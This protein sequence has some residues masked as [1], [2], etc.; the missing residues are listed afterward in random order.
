MK[1]IKMFI[2]TVGAALTIIAGSVMTFADSQYLTPAEALAELTARGA[3]SVINE[4]MRTGKTYGAIAN[5]AGVLN[6]FKT[7]MLEMRKAALAALV[8]A[9]VVTQKQADEIIAEI[10]YNM[11]FCDGG[12]AGC[13][14][15]DTGR[16]MG[17]G[18]G[19]RGAGR[20]IGCGRGMGC[21][22]RNGMC[23]MKP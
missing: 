16:G 14:L 5:E 19:M 21:G 13:A 4:R 10:V 18:F 22:L 23:L 8:A 17:A 11:A 3:Q 12:G 1:S 20:G 9:G 7:E 6:E 15:Y 2:I